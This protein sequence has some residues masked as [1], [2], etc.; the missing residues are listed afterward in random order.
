VP[1]IAIRENCLSQ[2]ICSVRPE[3]T[4]KPAGEILFKPYRGMSTIYLLGGF[5]RGQKTDLN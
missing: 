4:A 3:K 1:Y 5:A 2:K